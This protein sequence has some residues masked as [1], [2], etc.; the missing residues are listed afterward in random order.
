MSRAD[1]AERQLHL[2]LAENDAAI[3]YSTVLT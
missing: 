3:V 2:V 1:A